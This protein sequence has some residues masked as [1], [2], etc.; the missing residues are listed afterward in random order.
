MCHIRRKVGN[1]NKIIYF[2]KKMPNNYYEIINGP[3]L[4]FSRQS[5][6][7][8]WAKLSNSDYWDISNN[9]DP[10]NLLT[11]FRL[12]LWNKLEVIA[13]ETSDGRLCYHLSLYRKK[14]L[15]LK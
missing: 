14:R 15:T 5:V 4:E 12:D 13:D 7:D 1:S 9:L 8:K 11:S 2:E 3:S 10:I 6:G